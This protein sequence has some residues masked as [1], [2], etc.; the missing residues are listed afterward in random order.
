MLCATGIS[1]RGVLYMAVDPRGSLGNMV[2]RVR[3]TYYCTDSRT[4]TSAAVS[5]F[6]KACA[7]SMV[8]LFCCLRTVLLMYEING[9]LRC[10]WLFLEIILQRQREYFYS[11]NSWRFLFH[12]NLPPPWPLQL[13]TLLGPAE[14]T[15]FYLQ[16]FPAFWPWPIQCLAI[17][18]TNKNKQYQ[19]TPC[20]TGS[21]VLP[22]RTCGLIASCDVVKDCKGWD[23]HW[24]AVEP[25]RNVVI[26]NLQHHHQTSSQHIQIWC[27]TWC[28]GGPWS[29]ISEW[30][31]NLGSFWAVCGGMKQSKVHLSFGFATSKKS[32][33]PFQTSQKPRSKSRFD[34]IF[35]FITMRRFE[36]PPIV[37]G[38]D[39]IWIF[40]AT[41]KFFASP[42]FTTFL[43]KCQNFFC[44]KLHQALSTP[45]QCAQ[46]TSRLLNTGMAPLKNLL[47]VS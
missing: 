13:L 37:P 26:G 20:T 44:K 11:L 8:A 6:T 35:S 24:N 42:Q 36:R 16:F 3:N 1:H 19:K 12:F 32:Q 9:S 29:R 10:P 4:C 21:T 31:T 23:V 2:E 33:P 45:P 38:F 27:A 40:F 7:S 39:E 46:L 47:V 14:H 15:R 25:E 28:I 18:F 43:R 30:N 41:S 22:I 34:C 5:L 17:T